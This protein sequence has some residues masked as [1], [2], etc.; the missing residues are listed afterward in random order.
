MRYGRSETLREIFRL[1][2][3]ALPRSALHAEQNK[4]NVT[5]YPH[6]SLKNLKL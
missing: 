1:S 4:P 6:K 3:A 5:R 2:V